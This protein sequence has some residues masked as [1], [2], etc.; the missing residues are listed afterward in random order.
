MPS[1]GTKRAANRARQ[2]LKLAA[3]SLWHSQSALGA[4]YRPLQARMDTAKANTAT[5]HK[6]GRMFYFM[7]T[8]GEAF[9]DQGQQRYEDQQRERSVA[10][11]R[12]RAASLGFALPQLLRLPMR[13]PVD[14]SLSRGVTS[15][16]LPSW[17][18]LVAATWRQCL[19]FE[20]L[21][22]DWHSFAVNCPRPI[23]AQQKK[24]SCRSSAYQ[25]LLPVLWH[26]RREARQGRSKRRG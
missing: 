2:A 20:V 1:S 10:A 16:P 24:F 18:P 22:Q 7:L 12:R 4:L 14:L 8:R 13:L 3:R 6:L 26:S 19:P 21:P 15:R 25:G 9:L 5:A 11:L 23:L 17:F